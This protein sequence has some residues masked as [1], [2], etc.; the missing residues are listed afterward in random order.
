MPEMYKLARPLM[1]GVVVEILSGE[2]YIVSQEYKQFHKDY[3]PK[4]E[5]IENK[6]VRDMLLGMPQFTGEIVVG[7][8]IDE[9]CFEITKLF[10]ESPHVLAPFIY[11][12]YDLRTTGIYDL[13][14]RLEMAE[15]FVLTCGPC[16]QYVDHTLIESEAELEAYKKTVTEENH[17]PGIV[18]REPFGTYGT[19]ELII[20]SEKAPTATAAN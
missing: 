17:F 7:K 16:I 8:P 1:K 15:Q 9:D 10:L 3:R 19:E 6:M 4:R 14:R 13:R 18:L 11:W 12:V 20:R 2:P 5:P